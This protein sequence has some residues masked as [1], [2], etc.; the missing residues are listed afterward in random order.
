[1]PGEV[2]LPLG[3]L[4]RAGGAV[5]GGSNER[6]LVLEDTQGY[7]EDPVQEEAAQRKREDR[8]EAKD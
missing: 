6:A 3:I 2:H 7:G 4:Q 5:G 1:L 8:V